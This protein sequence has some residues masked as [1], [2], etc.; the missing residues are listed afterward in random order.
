MPWKDVEPVCGNGP[1]TSAHVDTLM[2]ALNPVNF[3]DELERAAKATFVPVAPDIQRAINLVPPRQGP[4]AGFKTDREVLLNLMATGASLDH[5]F[6]EAGKS[7]FERE[8]AAQEI[9]AKLYE[10]FTSM[11]ATQRDNYFAEPLF[12]VSLGHNGKPV[13][14]QA[15][16]YRTWGVFLQKLV[17]GRLAHNCMGTARSII[18]AYATRY[19]QKEHGSYC[20][21]DLECACDGVLVC[22]G[23]GINRKKGR[24]CEH[25]KCQARVSKDD[26]TMGKK[27]G[28]GG[29]TTSAKGSR[30]S[31]VFMQLR[32][33]M[34]F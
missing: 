13:L 33:K 1:V 12:H 26:S 30:E 16:A 34:R 10:T 31:P 9:L 7:E 17:T 8:I 23:P 28:H 22:N 18:W 14:E 4:E 11:S 21:T 6:Q 20:K 2:H 27:G 25:N 24:K 3:V 15:A 29:P 5:V 19:L 32:A